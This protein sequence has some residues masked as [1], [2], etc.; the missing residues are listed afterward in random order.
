MQVVIEHPDGRRYE[1]ASGDFRRGKHVINPK[2]AELESFEAAGFTIV[3]LANGQPYEAP[4][5]HR[6]HAPS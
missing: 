3:A 2:T 5:Q 4:S 6:E 1:I